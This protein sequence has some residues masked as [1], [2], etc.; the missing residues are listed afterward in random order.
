DK[1]SDGSF[2][3]YYSVDGKK[4][5]KEVHFGEGD[6]HAYLLP[7]EDL[8]AISPENDIYVYIQGAS[9]NN[10]YKIEVAAKPAMSDTLY[11]N[12][13][14]NRVIGVD[15][16]YEWRY[17][18]AEEI[19]T[20]TG[21]E[22]KYTPTSNWR[23]YADASPDCS[24]NKIIEV[25]LKG[26]SKKP[27]SDGRIFTFTEDTDTEE[28]KYISVNYLSVVGYSTQPKDTDSR[29]NY[30]DN[31]IDGNAKTYWHTDYD[32]SIKETAKDSSSQYQPAYL[33]IKID[34][35]R[36]I[37]GLDF[38]QL[39]YNSSY[40][41]FAKKVTVYVSVDGE[42][43]GDPVAIRE[44][45][46]E[47][48]DLK[49]VLFENAVY[50][51]YVK[52]EMTSLYETNAK[53][54]VFTTV[55]L[56]NLYEDT[57]KTT[58]PTGEAM[59][60]LSDIPPSKN[61]AAGLGAIITEEQVLGEELVADEEFVF[62][63]GY[64]P[65]QKSNAGVWI[66]VSVVGGV[67]IAAA[68]VVFVLYKRGIIK[69][70]DKNNTDTGSEPKASTTATPKTS[71]TESKVSTTATPKAST[72]EAK[73]SKTATPKASTTATPKANTADSKASATKSKASTPYSK[74]DATA[75]K[76]SATAPKASTAKS[77]ASK[78]APKASTTTPKSSTT[79]SKASTT[80]PKK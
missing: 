46:E 24:G 3:W 23:C 16:T 27:A 2:T 57:T 78:T 17:C 44:D 30:A 59:Q 60:S 41:I 69:I 47:L 38:A 71:T 32:I 1:Y 62:E 56:V 6:S 8:A 34:V 53:D 36:W 79:K 72:T 39:Q 68:V 43:W 40:S 45:L 55:S 80:K 28:R 77:E 19:E 64:I 4:T 61:A 49:V 15:A 58:T 25:R 73:A 22:I 18:K 10:A 20:E 54:G 33:N 35:P 63:S 26:T 14:E 37:S 11:A 75:P 7:E 13:W 52:L 42:N 21:T 9:S 12:D 29:K 48:D 5:W 66:A 31:A 65:P 70:G 74:I 76:S 50:G 67:L 51:Q